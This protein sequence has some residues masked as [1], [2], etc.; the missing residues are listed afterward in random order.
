MIDVILS[1]GF[2]I[3][4]VVS[5][6]VHRKVLCTIDLLFHSARLPCCSLVLG[7]MSFLGLYIS[8]HVIHNGK[9]IASI[10]Q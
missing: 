6:I 4:R 8:V 5:A 2:N 3:F 7:S 1:C 9:G 10:I